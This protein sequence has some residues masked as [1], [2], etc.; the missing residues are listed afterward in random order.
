MTLQLREEIDVDELHRGFFVHNDGVIISKGTR[1][2]IIELYLQLGFQIPI[3]DL[4]RL[5]LGV[6]FPQVN[7]MFFLLVGIPIVD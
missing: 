7:G 3:M 5:L 4:T 1:Q 2:E 6:P